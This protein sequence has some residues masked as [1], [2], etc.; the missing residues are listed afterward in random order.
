MTE[1]LSTEKSTEFPLTPVWG[2]DV[3]G[4]NLKLCA[5]SGLCASRPFPMWTDSG[6]LGQTVAEMMA[7]LCR[8]PLNHPWNASSVLAVTMTGELADCFESRREGVK[9]ILSQ[10]A[11]VVPHGQCRVYAVD[12]LWMSVDQAIASPWLVAASNWHALATWCLA[13]R[14][15]QP[16]SYNAVMD[17][18]STT[19]DIIPVCNGQIQTAAQTDR[20]RLELGQL[21]YTGMERTPIHAI[22]RSLRVQG[23]R[24]PVIAERFATIAD[25]NLVLDCVPEEPGNHDTADG[26]PRTRRFALARLAR[27]VGEDLDTLSETEICSL[28]R[29]ICNVQAK[30]VARALVRNLPGY[31]E[32]GLPAPNLRRC[33]LVVGHGNPLVARL[34]RLKMLQNVRFDFLDKRLGPAAARCAPALA[35]AQLFRLEADGE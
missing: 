3:G 4:A 17:V 10:L 34:R 28:A 20:Q 15:D 13:L 25:A 19:V 30:Q 16:G 33:V 5:P 7:E 18:G 35:V 9:H 32:V 8:P 29:Q 23:A 2:I 26:R 24:C 11:I 14:L 21:V 1:N 27:M 31:S 6:V 12:G 22:V